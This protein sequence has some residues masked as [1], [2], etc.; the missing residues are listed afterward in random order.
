MEIAPFKFTVSRK[1]SANQIIFENYAITFHASGNVELAD[2]LEVLKT[3]AK[4][5]ISHEKPIKTLLSR[6]FN[7]RYIFVLPILYTPKTFSKIYR[8]VV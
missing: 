2:I 7:T 8:L 1:F 3:F 6:L 4:L 5:A